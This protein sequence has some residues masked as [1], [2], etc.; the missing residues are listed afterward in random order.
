MVRSRKAAVTQREGFLRYDELESLLQVVHNLV[1]G[2][3]LV[4]ELS[5][6]VGFVRLP[7]LMGYPRAAVG[8]GHRKGLMR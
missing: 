6:D 3:V 5:H 4:H 8:A 1:Q 2:P 7:L